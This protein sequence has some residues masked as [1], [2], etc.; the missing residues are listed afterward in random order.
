MFKKI[1]FII[2]FSGNLVFAQNQNEFW[3][4]ITVTK[5]INSHWVLG[6]DAQHR[7]QADYFRY[8]KN[9]FHYALTNSIRLWAFYKLKNKWTI[10][11][12][13]IGYFHN[14]TLNR[15]AGILIHSN[16]LRSM[17]GTSK[18]FNIGGINNYN[19]LLYEADLLGCESPEISIRNRY[20]LFNN[21]IFP[22]KQIN[23]THSVNYNLYNEIFL[24]TEKHISSF[25]QNHFYNGIQWKGK[26]CDAN[27]GY[28][29][30]YQKTSNKYLKKNQV[31]FFMNFA[32]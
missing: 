24:K 9:I 6:M 15:E 2:L 27:I 30:T 17:I 31:L 18:S 4:R 13:P 25:D 22:L 10:V 26:N 29:Y 19:R 5:K 3:S 21:F 20:R 12:S 32:I 1:S 7:R 14:V 8:E 16:E 23:Q 11:A 28:Q